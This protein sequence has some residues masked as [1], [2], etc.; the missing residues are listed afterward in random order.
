MAT[1]TV[2]SLGAFDSKAQTWEEYS[3]VGSNCS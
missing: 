1:G 2:G 3:E